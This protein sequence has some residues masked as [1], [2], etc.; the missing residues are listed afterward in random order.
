MKTEGHT[1]RILLTACAMLIGF[2][3][4]L[5]VVLSQFFNIFAPADD[6]AL[7]RR[8]LL[9]ITV[10]LLLF[11]LVSL[12]I[13]SRILY[14]FTKPVD[15]LALVAG[16]LAEGDFKA[17]ASVSEFSDLGSLASSINKI[18]QAGQETQVVRLMEKERLKTLIESIGS[19]LLM[20][21]R[22]GTVNLMNG[23]FAQ[24]F[25]TSS[26]D[27]VGKSYKEIG[28][29]PDAEQ[30][31]ENVFLSEQV[32]EQPIRLQ[33]NG[34]PVHLNVYG[35][36]V[37]GR[38]GNWLGIIVVFHD[39]SKIIR[40]EEIRK[41]FV[42]NV[43]HELRTPVTSIKGFA[44]TLLDGALDQPDIAREFVRIIEK[45][46]ARL[47][48]L[49]SDLL[50]LSGIEQHSFTL[51]VEQVD[52]VSIIREAE[53]LVSKRLEEKE[54]ILAV[55][56]PAKANIEGDSRRLMQ[57]LVNLLAN[58]I[59]YS[60]TGTTVRI[61]ARFEADSL[62]LSVADEG[63]GIEAEKIPRLFER[64]YRADLARSRDSG[65]TG[66]GLAI[67]KHLVEAHGGDI[68]VESKVGRGSEFSVRLPVHQAG[69]TA[70]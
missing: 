35:A 18:A 60:K 26:S 49:V 54:M 61:G 30:L 25:H 59:A 19:S 62:I 56:A 10:V 22:G 36:P 58:A 23:V 70:K 15:E 55:E 64:F 1:S 14:H 48:S 17:R 20:L 53:K 45:E 38:H 39:I 47:H 3:V 43:S 44:E 11:L 34:V 4:V 5:W 27:S 21:G 41:D 42:A 24:T 67:V 57:V 33:K 28:L 7:E 13:V 2:T 9:F 51:D 46:S 52:V 8:Y 31:I 65:G 68:H 16:K 12:F 40:L 66:L 32:H 63:I 50:E 69:N 29:P 6:I 37:I